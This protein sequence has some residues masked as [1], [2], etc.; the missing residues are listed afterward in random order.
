MV[1]SNRRLT[2]KLQRD[3]I[4]ET[5]KKIVFG[6]LV[7]TKYGYM[8]SVIPKSNTTIKYNPIPIYKGTIRLRQIKNKQKS[9]KVDEDCYPCTP[10]QQSSP[11][12]ENC[13]TPG[14]GECQYCPNGYPAGV[15][16]VVT[17]DVSQIPGESQIY[18]NAVAIGGLVEVALLAGQQYVL[19]MAG[20]IYNIEDL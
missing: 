9:L 18:A 16:C 14:Y 6:N 13:L 15:S 3:L 1:H 19:Q 10:E 8:F 7:K 11:A 20:R 12:A 17:S 4:A 2:A 5:N